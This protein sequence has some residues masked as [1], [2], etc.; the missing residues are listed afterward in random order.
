MA[1]PPPSPAHTVWGAAWA[2]GGA[3]PGGLRARCGT[4][5]V[6][7]WLGWLA[8]SPQSPHFQGLPCADGRG[9]QGLLAL[10]SPPGRRLR[11][12]GGAFWFVLAVWV[13]LRGELWGWGRVGWAVLGCQ[14]WAPRC[15]P[16]DHL[17][18]PRVKGARWQVSWGEPAHLGQEAGRKQKGSPVGAQAGSLHSEGGLHHPRTY[19]NK[20]KEMS[21]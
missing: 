15:K 12:P 3:L 10:G 1:P 18:A 13:W 21:S 11:G 19:V 7:P 8:S 6:L 14:V 2:G 4:F 9:T 20:G 16:G 17:R 5:A